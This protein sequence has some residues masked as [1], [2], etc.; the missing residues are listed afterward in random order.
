MKENNIVKEAKNKAIEVLKSC[1]Q[2]KGFHASGLKGGYEALWSRD[3]MTCSLG[4]SLMNGEF[5]EAMK[6]SLETLAKNQTELGL[7]PNCVGSYNTERQSDVTFN[8]IDAPQWYVI[9]HYVYAKAYQ[10]ETLLKKY[11]HSILKTVSW[12]KHQDPNN[13]KVIVQ[14]PTA[15]WMD[16]FPHKYG[17]VMHTQA[18]QYALLKMVGEEELAEQIKD[19]VNGVKPKY[20]ALYDKKLG[21][22]LPWAWK[23]HGGDREQEEWFDSGAN[24]LAIITGLATPTIA[25]KI[26]AFIDKEQINRPYQCKNLWPPIQPGSPAWK[27]YFNNC[28]A[29]TPLNYINGGI[30]L[31]LGGLYIAALVKAKQF[32]K[33]ES[34]LAIMAEG[35]M[36]GLKIRDMS[37][38]YEFN[39]WLDGKTG[40]PKG[41]PYQAWTAGMYLYAFECVKQKKVLYFD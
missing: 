24:L 20:L 37:K 23:D 6:N 21:Y 28:D 30:W 12:L 33:A 34:E 36:Q 29:R 16:A 5:K 7:I 8:S 19:T 38:P 26:L 11:R 17:R 3:S 31:W 22:Y 1:I 39:E 41:E 2:P 25:K 18:L 35:C 15:D 13:D 9:G 4:A 40:E 32:K 27:P 10:D 14:Q